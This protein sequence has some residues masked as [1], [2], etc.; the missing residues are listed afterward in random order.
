M[1][2][3]DLLFKRL[4]FLIEDM[5]LLREAFT[6]KSAVNEKTKGDHNERLEFLGDAVL[7]LVVTEYLFKTYADPEG[8]LTNYRSA[9]VKGENLANVSRRLNL[10]EYIMLSKGEARSGGAEKEYLLANLLEAFIGCIY[11]DQGMERARSFIQQH[12]LVDLKDILEKGSYIDAKS[13]FQEITQGELGITP[14]YEVLS[15]AG[16]DHEKTFVIGAFLEEKQ[17]GT[18]EGRSKKEAQSSAATDALK[19][20]KEWIGEKE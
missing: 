1:N 20:K 11:L 3:W 4:G 16:L 7:E 5:D 12:I 13:Q 19:K 17:V 9:L 10:G 18:G 14:H 15:E 8:V 6:H 2:D